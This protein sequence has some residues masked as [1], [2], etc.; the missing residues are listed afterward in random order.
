MVFVA[1]KS[2]W[3]DL[4]TKS[5]PRQRLEE[6]VGL[7]G[8]VDVVAEVSKVTM[9]R[10][11]VACMM[12]QTARAQEEDP[13]SLT[14]SFDL[15]IMVILL[16]IAVVAA[17][18]FLWWCLDRCCGEV[19]PSRSA[20]KLKNLQETIQREIELQMAERNPDATASSPA[21]TPL[22]ATTART[23]LA[24]SP[25]TRTSR[26]VTP[27]TRAPRP[28]TPTSRR[29]MPSSRTS[30]NQTPTTMAD[31]GPVT[32]STASSSSATA[33]GQPATSSRTTT[34]E[35]GVQ[36]DA[37]PLICYQDRE[38]PV[39]VPDPASWTHPLYVSP[40]GDT[41]HTFENCWGLRNTRA[42]AVR[43]CQ[44]CRDNHG[45]SLRDR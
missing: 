9:A 44:C 16:G 31:R 32:T 38:V 13:L 45:R 5:F 24:S 27:T 28:S 10:M 17:W 39:A 2:Q 43:F 1:G 3:A 41:Y 34:R 26:P 8:F 30:G 7:W 21:R 15:Y 33:F 11:L 4:L 36:I 40:S 20:R 6:L 23:P 22:D 18:E 19:R 25:I 35:A 37:R 29:P 12:V 42:R 14:T